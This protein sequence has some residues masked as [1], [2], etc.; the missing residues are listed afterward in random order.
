MRHDF[1]RDLRPN[2][3]QYAAII[4]PRFNGINGIEIEIPRYQLKRQP[5]STWTS[6]ASP[7]WWRAYNEAKHERDT[8]FTQANLENTLDS[9]YGLMALLIY[10]YKDEFHLQPY[11]SPAELRISCEYR[12]KQR[13]EATRRLVPI[14]IDNIP[15]EGNRPTFDYYMALFLTAFKHRKACGLNSAPRYQSR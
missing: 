8:N 4:V 5:L 14:V 7:I 1:S 9:L 10:H 15:R 3:K 6:G 12:D 2:I 11:P 13:K